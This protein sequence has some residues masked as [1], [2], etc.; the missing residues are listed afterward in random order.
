MAFGGEVDDRPG[1]VGF[2]ERANERGV[3]DAPLHECMP[4]FAGDVGERIQIAGVRKRI[5]VHDGG[6]FLGDPLSHEF[7]ADEA[8][9]AGHEDGLHEICSERREG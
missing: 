2:E 8:G 4:G 7:T 3:A 5:E 9:A 1:P 6:S